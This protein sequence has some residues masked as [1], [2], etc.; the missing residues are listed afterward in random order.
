VGCRKIL[1]E[2]WIERHAPIGKVIVNPHN[3]TSFLSQGSAIL[4]SKHGARRFPTTDGGKTWD[5]VLYKDENTG[6]IDV[7]FDPQNPNILFAS[8]WRLD[9]L[10]GHSP[11]AVR[12][13]G[14]SLNRRRL[15][16]ETLQ[17][18]EHGLPKDRT[19]ASG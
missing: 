19:V 5:K 17:E 15:H 1:E 9:G 10:H 6:A 7:V 14:V 8:L 12:A 11:A 18:Q 2:R 13:R 4:W 16:L 3:P